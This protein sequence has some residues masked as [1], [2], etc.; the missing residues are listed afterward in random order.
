MEIFVFSVAD[1]NVFFSINSLEKQKA[2]ILLLI[3]LYKY[4]GLL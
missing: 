1:W 2:Y 4:L 3:I